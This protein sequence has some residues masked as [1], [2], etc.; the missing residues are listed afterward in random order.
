[1]TPETEGASAE[2]SAIPWTRRGVPPGQQP[3]RAEDF[4][5]E[6]RPAV[7]RPPK[8]AGRDPHTPAGGLVGTRP[9]PPVDEHER[10]APRAQA[11]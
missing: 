4:V 11:K 8:P 6:R 2:G 9:E 1:M 7:T 3:P 5:Q 10:E